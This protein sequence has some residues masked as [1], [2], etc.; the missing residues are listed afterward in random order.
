MPVADLLSQMRQ[1]VKRV[2]LDDFLQRE[3]KL[4]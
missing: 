3:R 1:A 4:I 2:K